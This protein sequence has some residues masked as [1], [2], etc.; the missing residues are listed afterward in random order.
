MDLSLRLAGIASNAF[1]LYLGAGAVF[2]LFF[3]LRGGLYR[4]DPAARESSRPFRW[5]ILP[6]TIVLWPCLLLLWRRRRHGGEWR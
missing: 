4:L 2:A 1:F 3:L 5:L 6:G